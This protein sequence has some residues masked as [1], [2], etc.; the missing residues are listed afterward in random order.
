MYSL[1]ITYHNALDEFKN[2]VGEKNFQDFEKTDIRTLKKDIKQMQQD[3]KHSKALRNLRRIEGFI[4]A[5]EQFGTVVEVFLNA[6]P[7]VCFVWGPIKFLLMVRM[8]SI[9]FRSSKV[10][11]QSSYTES[12]E[13]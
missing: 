13:S 4:K 3:Q 6:S 12:D 8:T 1:E 11:T 9:R 7:I 10:I 2:R 5:F